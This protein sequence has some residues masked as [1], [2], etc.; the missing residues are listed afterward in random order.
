M[1]KSV[2]KEKKID[3]DLLFNLHDKS[4]DGLIDIKELF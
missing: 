4:G 3:I 1:L 2:I